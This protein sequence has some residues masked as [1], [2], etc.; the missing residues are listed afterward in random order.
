MPVTFGAG[1]EV[2][3]KMLFAVIDVIQG[4]DVTFRSG[5]T[6]SDGNGAGTNDE[7]VAGSNPV[8]PITVTPTM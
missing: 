5:G 4:N 8:T 1:T 3:S 2:L 6:S 7:A